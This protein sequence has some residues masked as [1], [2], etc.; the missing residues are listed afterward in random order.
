MGLGDFLNKVDDSVDNFIADHN[1]SYRKYLEQDTQRLAQQKAAGEHP[2]FFKEAGGDI[3]GFDAIV[4][5]SKVGAAVLDAPSRSWDTLFLTA[6]HAGAVGQKEGGHF[7]WGQFVSGKSW[8]KAWNSWGDPNHVTAGQIFGSRRFG[9]TGDDQVYNLDP[10][11]AQDAQQIQHAA[12]DTWVG[13]V[14]SGATDLGL[15]MAIPGGGTL[16]AG[17]EAARASSAIK[18][19]AEAERVAQRFSEVGTSEAKITRAKDLGD[20]LLGRQQS[21]DSL[22]GRMAQTAEKTDGIHDLDTML[23]HLSPMMENSTDAAKVAIADIFAQANKLEDVDLRNGVKVNAL[24]AAQ[25]SGTARAAL[26][27]DYPLLAKNLEEMS[28]APRGIALAE[29]LR[30][31]R[32]AGASDDSIN[33]V[34]DRHYGG[35]SDRAELEALRD[36]VA[37]ASDEA[38]AARDI[39]R[40]TLSGSED[41]KVAE[42][43][44]SHADSQVD[45]AKGQ[46]K[47]HKAGM[48]QTAAEAAQ[49]RPGLN[50]AND[51]LNEVMLLGDDATHMATGRIAPT[52]LD[53]AKTKL[54][55]MA[56]DEHRMEFGDGN[57][58]VIVKSLAS[59]AARKALTPQARG[60]ISLMDADLGQRQLADALTRSGQFSRAEVKAAQQKLLVTPAARRQDVVGRYQQDMLERIAV[61]HFGDDFPDPADALKYAKQ[62]VDESVQHWG[63]GNK[64]VAKAAGEQKGKGRV[65]YRTPDG[66]AV[67]VDDGML[68]SHLA[69]NAPFLDP[70]VFDHALR[71]HKGDM[72]ARMRAGLNAI[73]RG[74]DFATA[75]WKHGALLR[76][77][78]A[79]RAGLDTNLRAMALMS[80]A[81]TIMSGIAGAANLAHNRG[82]ALA[83]V[84]VRGDEDVAATASK[85]RDLGMTPV[86]VDTGAG[87]KA[88]FQFHRDEADRTRNQM[89]M[90]KGQGSV[91]KGYFTETQ[92]HL[93]RYR[94][95]RAKWDRFKANSPHWVSSYIEYAELLMASPTARS[96]AEMIG[97]TGEADIGKLVN[98]EP[99]AKE[100]A[101]VGSPKGYTRWEFA[102]QVAHEVELMFPD[103]RLVAATAGHN[104]TPK[105]VEK[106]FPR[107]D[108]FDVPGPHQSAIKNTFGEFAQR[109]TAKMYETLLDKPD[110][111]LARNPAGTAI[112]RRQLRDEVADLR[113]QYD[114]QEIPQNLLDL[115]D[116]RA[117]AKAIGTVRRTFF[118]TT[119][120]TGMHHAVSK[121]SPFFA[122]WEDAM[123]SWSR[124]IHDDPTRLV[125]LSGAYNAAGTLNPY[126]PQP[127]LVDQDGK[128][129]RR[130]ES[131]DN[132]A[133]IAVPFKVK[134]AQMRVRIEA[135]NSIAQGDVWWLPGFGPQSQ[136]AATALLGNIP[137]DVA[138]DVVGTDNWVGKQLLRSMFLGG[139]VPRSD[140]A[141]LSTSVLPGWMRQIGKDA[142]G[143]NFAMNVQ[144]NANYR[145]IEAT[146]NGRTPNEAELRK[147]YDEAAK[148]ARTAAIVRLVSGT[149]L[150]MTGTASVEGQFYVDQMHQIEAIP[151]A[152]LKRMGFDSPE[153]YFAHLHPQAADLDWHLSR[154]ETGIVATANAQKNAYRLRGV[155]SQHNKDLG[156]MILGRANVD[157]SQDFSGSAYNMQVSSGDRK[158]MTAAE[159]ENQGLV[160]LGWKQY[161]TYMT[162]IEQGFGKFGIPMTDDRARAVKRQVLAYLTENNGPWAK[163]WNERPN[164]FA[165]YYSQAQALSKDKRLADRS[166][167]VKFREYAQ[168][169]QEVMDHFGLKSLSG[170]G[171]QSMAAK[172]VLNAAGTQLAAQD[173]GF[174][175]MWDR[176]LSNEVEES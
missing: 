78:L 142:F 94:T 95:E 99:F 121:V 176:F 168:A 138:L 65:M 54:R 12:T 151:P 166:D 141:T 156:W 159:V 23:A 82:S 174:Q 136:L 10:F 72:G 1:E 140:P 69:D 46:V 160:S 50:R 116:R 133:Y 5:N 106:T 75:M 96:L 73:E 125:K 173:F 93:G 128:P 147:I 137:Q 66:V 131:H 122:A 25:G 92:K 51:L 170:T 47:A 113:K 89:A 52:M 139:E 30:D 41:R 26:I 4:R 18:T 40:T 71:A 130:G 135:L 19:G 2:S 163:E 86:R 144:R 112:Y 169:R 6:A 123:I 55:L 62:A 108:R 171:Q 16:R 17:L 37:K 31:A 165:Y 102:R 28:G 22:I 58:P 145:I 45:V 57:T 111:W 68:Q 120:F 13:S 134:G 117:R 115:A 152:D 63:Q 79:V 9:Y 20:N 155:L 61:K 35:A 32:L 3:A 48:A 85:F 161:Q 77:G 87:K 149:G 49:A 119:R 126:L 148:T 38:K 118:D 43:L 64:W 158:K 146:K 36:E 124:L 39:R 83:R 103:Q 98:S 167:M 127:L 44:V 14:M 84:F 172:A 153:E 76:P 59:K 88:T 164:K 101:R 80:T 175:Q 105:M 33:A 70:E 150:G 74:N 129:L 60:S 90:T 29:D 109:W 162:Q 143:D 7:D 34:L 154:N 97:K 157:G 104:L 110:M 100:Y 11:D 27:R 81:E 107:G 15:S 56:G 42:G 91:Y 21:S 53:S 8:S 24:L 67:S 132:G 114:G